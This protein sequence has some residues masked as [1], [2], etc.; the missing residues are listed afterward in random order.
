MMLILWGGSSMAAETN[1]NF[2]TIYLGAGCFWCTEAVFERIDGVNSV[3][4][5]YMGGTLPDPSYRDVTSGKTGHAEVAEI[6]FNPETAPL[7]EILELFWK[8][9]DPTTLNRQGADVGTQYR[10]AIFFTNEAQQKI[11][12]KIRDRLQSGYSKPIV[13]EIT[14]A[15]TFYKAETYHQDYFN[16]NATAPYCQFVILPKLEKLQLKPE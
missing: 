1:S 9:H 6:V 12:E 10:S 11:A 13:T 2:S 8:M 7:K 16:N 3:T 14:P 4:V 5:G 15:G